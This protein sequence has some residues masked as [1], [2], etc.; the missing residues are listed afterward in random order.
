MDG[1]GFSTGSDFGLP[2]IPFLALALL[3]IPM[4]MMTMMSTTVAPTPVV[5][6]TVSVTVPTTQAAVQTSKYFFL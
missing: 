2:P 5:T 3:V 1:S 4:I 6:T